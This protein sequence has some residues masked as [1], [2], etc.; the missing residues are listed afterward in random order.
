[1]CTD[2]KTIPRVIIRKVWTPDNSLFMRRS[3]TITAAWDM[4]KLA[5]DAFKLLVFGLNRRNITAPE[6]LGY[7]LC[8][9]MISV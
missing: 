1:M 3:F 8:E 6:I 9:E 2:G 4:P 7:G 5:V